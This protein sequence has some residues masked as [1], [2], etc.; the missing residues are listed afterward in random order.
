MLLLP[1][2]HYY[3]GGLYPFFFFLNKRSLYYPVGPGTYHVDQV[4]LKHREIHL[5]KLPGDQGK[6][7]AP[8][9]LASFKTIS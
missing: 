2:F 4:G 8:L 1:Y 3:Y 6:R 5:P 7:C 9:C